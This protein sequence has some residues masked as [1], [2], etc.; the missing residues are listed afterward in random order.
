MN[1]ETLL[2]VIVILSAIVIIAIFVIGVVN[3]MRKITKLVDEL[4]I[5]FNDY[6]VQNEH[7]KLDIYK[8][9]ADLEE[10]RK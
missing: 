2:N 1:I 3:S 6:A 10:N 5:R 9:L 7:D 4:T 8:R